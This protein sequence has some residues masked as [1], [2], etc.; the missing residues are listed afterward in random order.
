MPLISGTYYYLD[1]MEI[2][3]KYDKMPP[4]S[5]Y[6]VTM[7]YNKSPIIRNLVQILHTL[8]RFPI[9]SFS[10]S[11]PP[12]PSFFPPSPS[13]PLSLPPSRY[14]LLFQIFICFVLEDTWHYWVHQ[15][16]HHRRLYKYVHKIHHHYQAPFGMVAEYAHPVETLGEFYLIKL[17][18]LF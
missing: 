10:P 13:L 3:Y 4:W 15:L 16:M 5:V 7:V 17:I 2:P 12:L 18:N 9:F 1:M 14:T 6:T 11:H 8:N